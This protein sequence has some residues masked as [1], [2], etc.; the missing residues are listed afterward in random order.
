MG[1]R[2]SASKRWAKRIG[3]RDRT[4]ASID[5]IF[6]PT[7]PTNNW[8]KSSILLSKKLKDS[9]KNSLPSWMCKNISVIFARSHFHLVSFSYSFLKSILFFLSLLFPLF[10]SHLHWCFFYL[11]YS[12][13]FKLICLLFIFQRDS[14]LFQY[15][16]AYLLLLSLLNIFF[17]WYLSVLFPLSP[18]DL[19]FI[20]SFKGEFSFPYS[21]FI[22]HYDLLRLLFS[23]WFYN[24]HIKM[25]WLLFFSTC[26]ML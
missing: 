25:L 1:P 7:N 12:L 4:L 11:L 6:R 26:P 19:C 8:S 16:I 10:S 17:F 20:V 21:H 22:R 13:F 9:L 15:V 24:F 14:S 5:S 2:D 23:L 3:F 18:Q